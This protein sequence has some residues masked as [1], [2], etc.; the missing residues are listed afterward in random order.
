MNFNNLIA[1]LSSKRR[2]QKIDENIKKYYEEKN[3]TDE[4]KNIINEALEEA[5]LEKSYSLNENYYKKERESINVIRENEEIFQ[6]NVKESLANLFGVIV[7]ESIPIDEE[8]K[9]NDAESIITEAANVFKYLYE[10]NIINITQ[11]PTFKSYTNSVVKVVED[12]NK[13]LSN[14]QIE[15]VLSAIF[16]DHYVDI[17]GT[18]KRVFD[19]SVLTVDTENKI[20]EFHDEKYDAEVM[21]TNFMKENLNRTLFRKLNEDSIEGIT[22]NDDVNKLQREDILNLSLAESLSNYAILEALNTTKLI[23]FDIDKLRSNVK[24]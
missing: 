9:E 4:N 18:I 22:K 17:D 2:Q 21:K 7:F 12:I 23:E 1:P 11:S 24:Y 16:Q 19:K 13:P 5:S 14:D 20:K 3:R 15:E 8:A 10:N 6:N